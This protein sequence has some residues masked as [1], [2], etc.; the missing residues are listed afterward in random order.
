MPTRQSD[1]RPGRAVRS[2][3]VR[4]QHLGREA[5]F[6]EQ[7]AHQLHGRSLIAPPLHEQ[8]ENLG[9]IVNR[10]PQPELP[11]RN[12]HGHLIEMPP[13]RW[14]R[15]SAA[16]FSGE[17]RPE[18][19]GGLPK[20]S[21]SYCHP[22][23]AGGTLTVL[24]NTSF[25]VISSVPLREPSRPRSF[26]DAAQRRRRR[27]DYVFVD[28]DH[29]VFEPFRHPPDTPDVAGIELARDAKF[30]GV[31]HLDR[32]LLGLEPKEGRNRSEGFPRALRR[33]S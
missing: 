7:L 28:A 25:R 31:H 13:Q 11:P 12:R 3:L 22:G 20:T 14:P 1:L 2:Q 24:A 6:L 26:F 23:E 27:G 18:L 29:A 4:H 21:N 15:A 19:R 16:K 30:R 17:Q 9:F 33:C 10:A 32:L 5:L 8:V